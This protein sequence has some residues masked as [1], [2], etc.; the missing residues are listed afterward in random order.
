[1]TEQAPTARSAALALW[2][3][4]GIGSSYDVLEIWRAEA[5]QVRGR[6]LDCGHFLPEERPDE[7]AS[8]LLAFL[9]HCGERCARCR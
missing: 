2:S 1:M 9:G 8:E 3:Q 4:D 6:A 7:V 5:D